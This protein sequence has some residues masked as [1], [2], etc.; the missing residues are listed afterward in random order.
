MEVASIIKMIQNILIGVIAFGIAVFWVVNYEN[1]TV[2]ES[3]VN[4]KDIIL[5]IPKF[6]FGFIG[7]SLLFSFI[8]PEMI[9]DN[10][11]PVLDGFRG[12][13]FT[14]AFI[15]IGLDS[16][17]KKMA[18]MVKNGKAIQLYLGGQLLNIILTLLAAYIFFSGHFFELPF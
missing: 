4:A 8:L 10:S 12:F 14:L 7:A 1:K 9:V 13:F 11:L 16:N 15:S 5:R 2:K 3:N 17:F 18:K 6:I